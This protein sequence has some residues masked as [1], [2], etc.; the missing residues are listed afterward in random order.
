MGEWGITNNNDDM[1][2]PRSIEPSKIEE[3]GTFT[4]IVDHLV[5]YVI[6]R[7]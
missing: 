7:E 1:S 3:G 6:Q 4:T 5:T 2:A